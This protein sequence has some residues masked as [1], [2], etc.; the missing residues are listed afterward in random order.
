MH[1]W[2]KG[3]C[4]QALLRPNIMSQT[5]L[6]PTRPHLLQP[7]PSGTTRSDLWPMSC[8]TGLLR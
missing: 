5:R 7:A 3:T 1:S 8:I 6:G 4:T 2:H